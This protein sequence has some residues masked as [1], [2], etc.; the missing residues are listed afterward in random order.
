MTLRDAVPYVA[1]AYLVVWVVVL[2]YVG[3]IARKMT[4]LEQQLDELEPPAQDAERRP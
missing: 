1:A 3:I 2:L 4:R